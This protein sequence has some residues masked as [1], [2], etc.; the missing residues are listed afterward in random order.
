[1]ESI[2]N[3]ESIVDTDLMRP[4]GGEQSRLRGMTI[5]VV[6]TA[7]KWIERLRPA[8][9]EI[10]GTRMIVADSIGEANRL[11]DVANAALVVLHCDRRG[12]VLEEVDQLLWTASMLRRRVP[13]VVIAD[14][15]REDQAA[16]LFR[17]GVEEYLDRAQH[18][19][20]LHHVGLRVI[21]RSSIPVVDT[22]DWSVSTTG[23]RRNRQRTSR[24]FPAA[25]ST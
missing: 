20:R 9:R 3:A 18:L 14:A 10:G 2:P 23:S 22:G 21:S 8:L 19:D 1:M 11:L 5:L 4:S 6:S 15:Y 12:L 16:L 13:V 7:R 25:S 24:R 17:L